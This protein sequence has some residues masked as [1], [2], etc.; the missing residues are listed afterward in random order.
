MEVRF[1]KAVYNEYNKGTGEGIYYI[2]E[3]SE[4]LELF[5]DNRFKYVEFAKECTSFELSDDILA[6]DSPFIRTESFKS[7]KAAVEKAESIF[8]Y[9]EGGGTSFCSYFI[10]N[11]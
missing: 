2:E 5:E 7:F 4:P 3:L 1:F 11:I 9:G 10:V 8:C 6:E